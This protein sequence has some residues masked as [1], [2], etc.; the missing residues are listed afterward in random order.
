VKRETN[1]MVNSG[2]TMERVMK[3]GRLSLAERD[4]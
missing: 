4:G 2:K 1:M 3:S